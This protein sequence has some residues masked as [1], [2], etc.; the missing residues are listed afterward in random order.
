MSLAGVITM[1][2]ADS[3]MGL[4]LSQLVRPGAPYI[5]AAFPDILDMKSTQF[6]FSGPEFALASAAVGDIMRYMNLPSTVHLGCTDS[7]V[8][9]GQAV[10]DAGTQIFSALAGGT[11]MNMFL[12][13]L[14]SAMSSSLEALVFADEAISYIR[15]IIQGFEVSTETLPE[16]LVDE[17]GPRGSFLDTDYTFEHV[18]D[19]WTPDLIARTSYEAWSRDGKKD[20]FVR[21]NEKVKAILTQGSQNP[22]SPGIREKLDKIVEKVEKDRG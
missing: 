16:D 21:C 18:R 11:C 14:E 9:D 4:V 5:M 20:L 2:L 22:L 12:G 15:R 19:N 1:G 7:P 6:T 8:F 17:V 10:F 13:Y 3:L